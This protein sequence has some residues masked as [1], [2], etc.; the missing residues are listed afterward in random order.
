MLESASLYHVRA[1]SMPLHLTFLI[2]E[3]HS[4]NNCNDA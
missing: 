1:D 2:D 4:L 3:V